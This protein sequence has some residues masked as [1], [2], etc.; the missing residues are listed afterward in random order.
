MRTPV[1]GITG[2]HV[3][4]E[5]GYGGSFR[6]V[7]GQGFSVV[8]H[9]YINAVRRVGGIPLG[10]PVGEIDSARE[11]LQALD[12]LIL[13]GGEDIDPSL[14]GARPDLR[15]WTLTPERDRFEL[16]LIEEA[17][18][19]QKPLLAVCRG[20]QLLNVYFGGSLYLDLADC[21][22]KVLSHQFSRAPR[23]YKAHK[24]RLLSPVLSEL[25]QTDEIETNSY[26]HQAVKEVGNGMQVA[27][28]AEDGIIEGL[29]H[30]DHPQ[31]LAI[32]WHPEMMS[33][34]LEEGLIPFR[35]LMDRCKQ[36]AGT[37]ETADS[38]DIGG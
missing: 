13:S 2:Y 27:A 36:A 12:G 5:E 17:L 16:A 11:V 28:V 15:C 7:P 24:V 31:L 26:H 25:Y 18:R 10:V 8:G 23:W 14:Y 38:K 1:I 29:L 33:V 22:N 30:P 19:Q 35:W 4:G 32:Q 37:G 9:D 21:S 3:L 20:M 6:G 34:Q